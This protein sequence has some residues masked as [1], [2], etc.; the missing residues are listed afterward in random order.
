MDPE[1][2][3]CG[4]LKKTTVVNVFVIALSVIIILYFGIMI[5]CHLCMIRTALKHVRLRRTL[6][7]SAKP[8]QS[9]VEDARSRLRATVTVA[10]I[11]GAFVVCW[12]PITFKFW[13][14][15]FF[16]YSNR[17]FLI[18]QV[19]CELPFYAN[20]M[21]NPIIYGYR[22]AQFRLGYKNAL[23][24]CVPCLVKKP[25]VRPFSFP[26]RQRPSYV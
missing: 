5:F 3:F 19:T 4:D 13:Y 18:V 23:H 26:S 1:E 16:T 21:I 6:S 22:N 14:Q 8:E 15:S 12:A 20:S 2:S 9:G 24:G 7:T 10:I 25:L 11:M 17:T